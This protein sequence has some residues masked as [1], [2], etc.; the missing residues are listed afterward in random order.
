MSAIAMVA[1]VLLVVI[2]QIVLPVLL[3]PVTLVLFW[4]ARRRARPLLPVCRVPGVAPSFESG[5]GIGYEAVALADRPAVRAVTDER[6]TTLGEPWIGS[7]TGR[8]CDTASDDLHAFSIHVEVLP[9][10]VLSWSV[11]V[12]DESLPVTDHDQDVERLAAMPGVRDVVRHDHDDVGWITDDPR[13]ADEMLADVL[14]A[15]TSQSGRG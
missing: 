14:R 9:D 2:T 6:P 8:T 11:H 7:G 10:G 12:D 3:L 5:T 4:L 15:V 1:L 13:P